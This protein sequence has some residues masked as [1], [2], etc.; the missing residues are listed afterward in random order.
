MDIEKFLSQND[1]IIRNCQFSCAE[2][3]TEHI[4]LK[5]IILLNTV[6]N[7]LLK[8]KCDSISGIKC[9]L[10]KRHEKLKVF[11][12]KADKHLSVIN[13]KNDKNKMDI[14]LIQNGKDIVDVCKKTIDNISKIKYADMLERSMKNRELCIGRVD[15]RNIRITDKI[16][17][18]TVKYLSYNLV[19]EDILNYL[20]K[21]KNKKINLN[22]LIKIYANLAGLSQD[23]EKYMQNI[24]KIPQESIKIWEKYSKNKKN[25]E[26]EFYLSKIKESFSYEKEI[27]TGRCVI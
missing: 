23:S 12:K 9:E 1:V 18:G 10:G 5:Q 8:Y 21:I 2:I 15:S 25:L 7:I 20:F 3:I 6:H 22:K 24:I 4:A 26:P 17:I 13:K 16:E 19:E 11:I 14:F 27:D